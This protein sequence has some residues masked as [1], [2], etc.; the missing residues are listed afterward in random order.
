[1]MLRISKVWMCYRNLA[2]FALENLLIRRLRQRN[3]ECVELWDKNNQH[4]AFYNF[5]KWE[6]AHRTIHSE[7]HC[8]RISSGKVHTFILSLLQF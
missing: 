6:G 2:T 3:W 8:V 5:D 7:L 1:M 4:L